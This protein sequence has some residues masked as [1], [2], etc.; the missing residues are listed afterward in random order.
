MYRINY[1]WMQPTQTKIP[2]VGTWFRFQHSPPSKSGCGCGHPG[3]D[4][5]NFSPFIPDPRCICDGKP[6]MI[7]IPPGSHIHCPVHGTP[8]FSSSPVW[9][10]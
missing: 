4:I 5:P 10:V 1:P 3:C 9:L 7:Y 6:F 8:I 2:S